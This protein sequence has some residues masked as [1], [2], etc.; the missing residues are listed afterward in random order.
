M[1]RRLSDSMSAKEQFNIVEDGDE[2]SR[3]VCPK[4]GNL[5][6]LNVPGRV[7]A[8]GDWIPNQLIPCTNPDCPALHEQEQQH[9]ARLAQQAQMPEEYAALTFA[10]WEALIAS[11]PTAMRGKWNAW[12]AAR[13]F[14]AAAANNFRFD[15]PDAARL[16][17]DKLRQ[18]RA[19]AHAAGDDERRDLYPPPMSDYRGLSV[20]DKNSVVFT[21]I[22]GVGKTSL[23]S[24]IT[25]A[26]LD[27]H[28]PVLYARTADLLAAIRHT[29]D[30]AQ[31]GQQ[32]FDWG[33]TEAAIMATF[34]QIPVLLLDEFGISQYTPWNVGVIEQLVRYRAA[35]HKATVFTTNLGYEETA[36][37]THWG[38]A[39]AHAVHGMAHW[40]QVGGIELRRRNGVWEAR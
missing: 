33:D 21:G 7:T 11:D 31:K 39:T 24:S 10:S 22:N 27:A 30:K 17:D 6:V 38:K 18:M 36:R 29:F 28:I 16:A 20:G 13:A 8:G 19:E 2:P 34:E 4:C 25:G 3:P 23:A 32:E 35:N 14:V 40:V 1:I 12:G 15:F 37:D 5:G 26:L 9:Y